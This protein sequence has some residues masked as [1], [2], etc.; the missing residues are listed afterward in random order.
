MHVMRTSAPHEPIWDT[1]LATFSQKKIVVTCAPV[2]LAEAV[3][4]LSFAK[5]GPSLPS[6]TG[7]NFYKM[8]IFCVIWLENLSWARQVSGVHGLGFIMLHCDGA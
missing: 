5:V 1:G 3:K 7:S 2:H 6:P 8:S 4:C